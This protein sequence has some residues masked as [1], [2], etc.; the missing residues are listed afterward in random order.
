MDKKK[1]LS[2]IKKRTTLV[3]RL[4][5][6]LEASVKEGQEVLLKMVVE[7]FVDK[8]DTTDGKIAD[9][10]RNKR[11]IASLDTI[12]TDYGKEHGLAIASNIVTGVQQIFDY[13]VA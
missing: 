7:D 8:L 11:L 13:N 1:A 10:I 9:T 12:F 3:N 2:L 5:D 6:R 4:S